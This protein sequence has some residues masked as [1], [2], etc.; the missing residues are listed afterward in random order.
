MPLAF[1]APPR[2]GNP[3]SLAGSAY[4]RA[5]ALRLRLRGGIGSP[6]PTASQSDAPALSASRGLLVAAVVVGIAVA[7]AM[8][9]STPWEPLV[10]S[11]DQVVAPD[12]D[13][14]FT[15]AEQAAGAAFRS[16]LREPAIAS[17]VVGL[18]A[19]A[20][21]GLTPLGARLV[22][23][24]PGAGTGR[25][26]L[27]GA[28]GAVLALLTVRV[29]TLPFAAWAEH[30]RRQEGLSTQDWPSWFVDVAK[31]F[32]VTTA[33]TTLVVLAIVW[34]AGRCARWWLL[35]APGAAVLAVA[36][37]LLYPVA[38]ERLFNEFTPLPAGELRSEVLAL[39][40]A[41]GDIEV[42]E[43]LVADASRRTTSLNAY[44][45]GF[46][47]TK[48]VV[49]Y[50]TLL[51][52]APPEEVAVVLAHELAHARERDVLT[53]T[54]LGAGAA[55]FGTLVLALLLQRPGLPR[56]AGVAA[57]ADPRAVPLVLALLAG[58]AALSTPVQHVLS[59]QV[60]ARAD[61]VALDLTR[62]P[63]VAAS[64]HRT[65]ALA[66]VADVDPPPALQWWFGSH[67]TTVDRIAL[68]RTWSTVNGV[69][70]PGDLRPDLS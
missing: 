2:T 58:L 29:A 13:R 67:P 69:R 49:L 37:S 64:M 22:G 56:R 28:L 15:A 19:A 59:R 54:L 11:P 14:D 36:T 4:H 50:D 3:A 16:Q 18:G 31:A 52:Q 53:G 26:V 25:L 43:V 68:T 8:L 45:S 57:V 41:A 9:L 33:M 35:A 27:P 70:P 7:V 21:L 66:S 48:R 5:M 23:R 65:L 61:V 10:A 12:A 46:G 20:V 60:E 44:V 24:L 42:G 30:L 34:L 47:A 62:S 32:G 17:L 40:E 6:G 38:V 51:A 39:A 63:S 1:R 55:A